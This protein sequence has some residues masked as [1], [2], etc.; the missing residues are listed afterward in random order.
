MD[1]RSSHI[2][3]VLSLEAATSRSMHY[4]SVV[5]ENHIAVVLPIDTDNVFRLTC[6]LVDCIDDLSG[7]LW[8]D[9]FH[10]MCMRCN[11]EVHSS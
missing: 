6:V 5:P 8:A 2:P 3:L 1:R 7:F 4:A 10:M 11:V 9:A